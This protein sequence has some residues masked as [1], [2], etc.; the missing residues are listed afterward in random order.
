[1]FQK[2]TPMSRNLPAR[3][4]ALA[5]FAGLAACGNTMERLSRVG[6]EPELSPITVPQSQVAYAPSAVAASAAATPAAAVAAAPQGRQ[7]N[8]LWQ[9]GARAFFKD[10][11]ASKV[12]D[13]L[14]VEI[15]IDDK[16]QLDNATTRNRTTGENLGIPN[17]LGLET[18]YANVL[19]NGVDPSNL[20]S[21][22][23]KSNSVGTGQVKRAEAVNMTVAAIVTQVLPNGNLVISG[24]QEVA[25][26]F[27]KRELYIGGIVRPEDITN[28]NTIKHTQIAEARIAYGGKGTLSDVQ[29]PRLGQQVMDIISPF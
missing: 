6:K 4:A 17:V 14:T 20:F 7:A 10:Q 8:S 26:N 11:R 5:L 15:S 22:N 27:E 24:H 12:G 3:L 25:V 18:K 23:S 2:G 13:I 9:P 1:M 21:A 16:A 28:R 29:Q 19:P